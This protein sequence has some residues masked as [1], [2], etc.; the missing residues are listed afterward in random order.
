MATDI[1]LTEDVAARF[2][3][4]SWNVTVA[5]A[6][7][8]GAVARAVHTFLAEHER[9]T[10]I[11]VRSHIGYSRRATGETPTNLSRSSP[12]RVSTQPTSPP[13]CRLRGPS[14]SCTRVRA[15]YLE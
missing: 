13:G 2:L 9:Q 11:L 8:L 6:N 10:L 14:P 3:A 12:P 7:A 15:W 5:D 1:A 4:Y